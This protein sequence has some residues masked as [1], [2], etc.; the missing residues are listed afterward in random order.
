MK[1]IGERE[2]DLSKERDKFRA[3]VKTVRNF[4]FT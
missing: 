3:F 4:H 2:L 1:E